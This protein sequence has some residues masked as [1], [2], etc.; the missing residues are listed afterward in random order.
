MKTKRTNKLLALLLSII[1]VA[2]FAA[3]S[4][5]AEGTDTAD[6][7][8][9]A[10]QIETNGTTVS[11]EDG[12]V[13]ASKTIAGTDTENVFDITLSVTTTEEL[14]EI[15][16][17]PDAATILVL[18]CSGS[19]EGNP[20][21]Q[22]KT[23]AKNF[24][25]NF[26]KDGNSITTAKRKVALVKFSE[27]AVKVADW[28]DVTN[29]T[30]RWFLKTQIAWSDADGGTNIEG[31]LQL[32]KN[33][34]DDANKPG[35]ALE[36]ISNVNVILLTDGCPTY[37]IRGNRNSTTIIYGEYGGGD[38]AKYEDWYPV[39]GTIGSG[40]NKVDGN[41]NGIA[42]QL[43]NTTVGGTPVSL[44]SI[45]CATAKEDFAT[46][47]YNNKKIK[48]SVFEW[49]K[50]FSTKAYYAKNADQL[51]AKFNDILKLIKLGAKAWKVED[52]MG[53]NIVY[54]SN[55]DNDEDPANPKNS[56]NVNA[57][58]LTWNL[59]AST[60][61][62]E[63]EIIDGKT[64]TK[65][66]YETTYRIALDTTAEG[67]FTN[68]PTNGDTVLTYYLFSQVDDDTEIPEEPDKLALTVPA[69]KGLFGNLTFKKVGPNDDGDMVPLSGAEFT[70]TGTHTGTGKSIEYT[71]ASNESGTVTF[72]NL[73]AGTYTLTETKAP[74]GYTVGNPVDVT[75]SYGVTY[76]DSKEADPTKKN[77]LTKD[78]VVNNR[79]QK[80][81]D[82]T[83]NKIWVDPADTTHPEI[84][85]NLWRDDNK[86]NPF[87][88]ETLTSGTTSVTF[89]GLPKYAEDDGHLY[90][91]TVTEDEVTGYTVT[92][93]EKDSNDPYA[94][95]IT[96][97]IDQA[98]TSLTVNKVW[99]DPTNDHPAITLQL[100]QSGDG[101]KNFTSY[102]ESVTL[103][104]DQLPYTFD[105]L[106]VYSE[107]RQTTYTYSVAETQADGYNEPA[108]QYS[109]DG[110][111]VTITNTIKQ[112]YITVEGT[113]TW[114]DPEGTKHPAITI[115][116]YQNDTEIKSQTLN[117][118]ETTYKFENLEKYASNGQ[119]YAYTVAEDEVPGYDVTYNGYNI[120]N[121]IKQ[122]NTVVV[123]GTKTWIDPADTQHPTITIN[124]L[125][126]G[127]PCGISTE[128]KDGENHYAFTGL[129]KYAPNGHVYEYT[130]SENPVEGYT[131]AQYGNN[132]TN[133][134]E[135]DSTV[136]VSGTK[137]WIAPEGTKVPD[138]TIVLKRDGGYFDSRVLKDGETEYSFTNL[139]KYD[140]NDGHVYSYTVEE[141]PVE[142]YTSKRDGTNFT[143]TIA[144]EYVS[145]SG[146]KKWT[147]PAD[148]V[149]PDITIVL[150][151]NGEE[152]KRT[153]LSNGQL[154]YAFMDLPKYDLETGKVY[155]YTVEELPVEGYTSEQEGTD[156]VNTIQQE[157]LNLNVKKV[158]V[159]ADGIEHPTIT[160]RLYQDE[161]EVAQLELK[162]GETE[163]TFTGW[164]RY[165]LTDGHAYQYTVR[166]DAVEG[167]TSKVDGF[168]VTN[169]RVV[170]PTPTPTATPAP[171][172]TPKPTSKPEATPEPTPT[173]VVNVP[174]TG[175]NSNIGLWA[176]LLVAAAAGLIGTVIIKKKRKN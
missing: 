158:W 121:T 17:S 166:E 148:A 91:Y 176:V 169:T 69:V 88:T 90:D 74:T 20:L 85:I 159:N 145:V 165:D 43:K 103:A 146:S 71:A 127:Q 3:T 120:T 40:N 12:K 119:P 107:D 96:N 118:G 80:N 111:T 37:H 94:W 35:G 116:L 57:N 171:T 155:V 14:S 24:I 48:Q 72:A 138:I 112:E 105:N 163:G 51:N 124:L 139:D 144:Q 98:Y 117:H 136:V 92:S 33:L 89:K 4:A 113:K 161:K 101:G 99:V 84:T 56:I 147:A 114:I 95:T 152:A 61:T 115:R 63:D 134:I 26:A 83:V 13:V 173:P 123:S 172:A 141:E 34:I 58:S 30:K 150:Y 10:V 15:H 62:K 22:A 7:S 167:Y 11:A 75:V 153:T 41:P 59:I 54:L 42:A 28:T 151:C 81:V 73:P 60:P 78:R 156:F 135:Q 1:M 27:S 45:A 64:V 93:N 79:E 149:H 174:A 46:N 66:H 110:K 140:L 53:T 68:V 87:K 44:Y 5:F 38:W 125:Q 122:D 162:N 168:T 52:P 109:E 55:Q 16:T 77:D 70:L 130:V 19:M 170:T 50:S 106:P 102:G 132:F 32:A 18:D 25:D 65:Y 142:G 82:V 2:S 23:A 49:L 67:T 39:G 129:A 164:D 131:S 133:T 100:M 104:S 21:S 175:D 160:V 108:Y 157:K 31:A 36:G 47:P 76:F 126:D 97:T 154:A 128:L 86:E 8:A 6:T 29:D 9:S 137:T 143:N